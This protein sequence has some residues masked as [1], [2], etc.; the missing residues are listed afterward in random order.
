VDARI[1]R[2]YEAG[3]GGIIDSQREVGG[4]PE[5]KSA[6]PPQDTDGDGMP[7]AWEAQHSLN[8]RDPSDGS[9]DADGDLYT[10][11]EEWLNGTDPRQKDSQ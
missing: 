6:P 11:I 7:D 2:E 3:T 5:L 8:P 1:L 4:Y 10:N 9:T